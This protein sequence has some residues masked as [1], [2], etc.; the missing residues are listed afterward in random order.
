MTA[1]NNCNKN[2]EQFDVTLNI[3]VVLRKT[4]TSCVNINHAQP[5]HKHQ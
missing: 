1:Y 3:T 4:T 5:S 2:I